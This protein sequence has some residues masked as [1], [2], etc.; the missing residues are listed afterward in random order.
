MRLLLTF[1]VAVFCLASCDRRN[2][3]STNKI[4]SF[5]EDYMATDPYYQPGGGYEQAKNK[6]ATWFAKDV[7]VG[8]MIGFRHYASGW[9]TIEDSLQDCFKVDSVYAFKNFKVIVINDVMKFYCRPE[10]WSGVAILGEFTHRLA[11]NDSL[12]IVPD[13][14]ANEAFNY[15]KILSPKTWEGDVSI[16]DGH[17]HESG[18]RL[19]YNQTEGCRIE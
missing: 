19:S 16:A 8:D 15:N 17:I 2:V 13:S 1:V 9:G 18:Y 10:Q 7:V 14:S 12:S 4:H 5:V 11:L 3:I 6:P